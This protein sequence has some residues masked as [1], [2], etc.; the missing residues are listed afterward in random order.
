[1]NTIR[2]LVL[3][4]ITTIGFAQKKLSKTSQSI[5]VNKDVVVDL[6]TSYA[7]IEISTWNKDIVEVEAYIESDKLT[8]EQLERALEA[9]NLRVDG[10]NDKVTISSQ[11]GK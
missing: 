9:W 4:L 3:C 1:M 10:S 5:K 2:I 7:E 8:E 11:G 6:N